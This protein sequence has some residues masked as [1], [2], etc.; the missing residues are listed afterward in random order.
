VQTQTD[1]LLTF[2]SDLHRPQT[3][4]HTPIGTQSSQ[5]YPILTP[6]ELRQFEQDGYLAVPAF[7]D[8][9]EVAWLRTMLARLFREH[10][11][12]EQGNQ[13]DM[14]GLDE[15]AAGARQPQI[16]KPS[17]F[18]PELLQTA[19]GIRASMIARQLLGPDARFSFDHSILKPAG[20]A[21]ATPWHQDEAHHP[22][23]LLRYP[24]ISFWLAL[25]DTS[26]ENGCMR[27]VPGSQRGPLLSHR[28]VNDDPRIHAIECG[29]E[30][31]DESMAIAT[32][33]AA[34]SCIMHGCRTLHA[35]LPNVSAQDRIAYVMAFTGPPLPAERSSR[36]SMSPGRTANMQ[37]RTRW[38]LR[39][40]F[41]RAAARRLSRALRAD[42]R[43]L[44]LK[45]QALLRTH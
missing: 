20:S 41:L 10:V 7:C 37:R 8:A 13:F 40:G 26:V 16:I 17:L 22:S 9:R 39:G 27:Y 18:A 5:L 43:A 42:P 33:V 21:A 3:Q 2:E 45:L 1:H 35:A 30:Q 36:I 34:G 11:G 32:P 15:K 38:L 23:R 28:R 4:S 25:Q 24:Q 44:W 12:R 14:L 31:F 6:E 19:Y 29:T